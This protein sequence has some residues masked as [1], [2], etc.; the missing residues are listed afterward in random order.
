MLPA[1]KITRPIRTV[2]V[3]ALFLCCSAAQAAAIVI[4]PDDFAPG[5]SMS[6]PVPGVFLSVLDDPLGTVV[7]S[8]AVRSPDAVTGSRVFG[9]STND[10][11]WGNGQFEFL[12]ARFESGAKS[13]SLDFATNDSSDSNAFL[14]AFDSRGVLLDSATTP[15]NM[16]QLDPVTLT[17][18]APNIAYVTASWD[19]E[20]RREN[21][22]LD[23]LVYE[24][25]D[26]PL[27]PF[28]RTI[29][30]A[31]EFGESQRGS[32]GDQIIRFNAD[33]PQVVS[34]VGETGIA[35]TQMSGLEFDRAN[36]LYAYGEQDHSASPGLYSINQSTGQATFIGLGGV[37]AGDSIADLSYDRATNTMYAIS[38]TPGGRRLYTLDLVSG[39]ATPVGQITGIPGSAVQVGLA[40]NA[41]GIRYVHDLGSDRMY[42]LDGLAAV[43]LPAGIS[44][45]S[46]ESQGMT[47]D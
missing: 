23:H 14:R 2:G 15:K 1:P 39:L 18:S 6:N 24:S 35:D 42:R 33:A 31:E 45:D 28:G 43:A 5:A 36:N 17:V 10:S 3:V 7:S 26:A 21:G 32:V 44:Y 34:I 25:A 4:D 41:N 19:D 46:N 30:A 29:W 27:P 13:V 22:V 40:T 9:H 8:S 47:I 16:P 20:T 38:S 37:M 11:A 12:R